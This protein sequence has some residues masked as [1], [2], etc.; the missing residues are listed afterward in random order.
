LG[1]RD[2]TMLVTEYARSVA[3][4]GAA[5]S[6]QVCGNAALRRHVAQALRTT[7]HDTAATR[8]E[9]SFR[10]SLV[11]RPVVIAKRTTAATKK[12][13]PSR[14]RQI[15]WSTLRRLADTLR[16]P[17]TVHWNFS[18][19]PWWVWALGVWG[20]ITAAALWLRWRRNVPVQAFGLRTG[21]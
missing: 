18:S 1:A 14:A 7:G 19:I 10:R 12:T 13:E 4:H 8:M 5:C 2:R 9:S 3:Y 21:S 20:Y 16:R 11:E 17:W 6:A 15:E